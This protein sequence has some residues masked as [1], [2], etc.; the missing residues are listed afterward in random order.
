MTTLRG[1]GLSP[2]TFN[3][4]QAFIED[5]RIPQTQRNKVGD[6]FDSVYVLQNGRR[7]NARSFERVLPDY[8]GPWPPPPQYRGGGGNPGPAPAQPAPTAPAPT[9]TT[10]TTTTPSG[11][12]DPSTPTGAKP[13]IQDNSASNFN[14]EKIAAEQQA[15]QQILSQ[16]A[17]VQAQVSDDNSRNTAVFVAV[18]GMLFLF[19]KSKRKGSRR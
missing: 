3:G 10:T 6:G 19:S 9:T 1:L 11:N 2:T 5:I 17:G 13:V 8:S 16:A 15:A 14:Y 7:V 12:L 4:A 18:L